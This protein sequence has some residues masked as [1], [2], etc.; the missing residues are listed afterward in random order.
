MCWQLLA[1][2]AIDYDKVRRLLLAEFRSGKLGAVSFDEPSK[3]APELP[4]VGTDENSE[5]KDAE[6]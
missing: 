6:E 1:G 4:A 2:G 5:E 3:N